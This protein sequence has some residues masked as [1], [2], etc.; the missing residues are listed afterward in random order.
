MSKLNH[1]EDSLKIMQKE[2][3]GFYKNP[4]T[5]QYECIFDITNDSFCTITIGT[6]LGLSTNFYPRTPDYKI[7][8]LPNNYKIKYFNGTMADFMTE[9]ILFNEWWNENCK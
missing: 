5:N 1:I 6:L 7:I 4:Y 8:L 3:I 2:V 9:P